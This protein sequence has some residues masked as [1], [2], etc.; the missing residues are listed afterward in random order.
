MSHLGDYFRIRRQEK[1]VTSG[2]L[3]RTVGYQNL[4]RGSNRIQT[5]E[6]GGKVAPDLLGKLATALEV[7]PDEVRRL[8]AEDYQEWL[9]WA[10]EPIRPHLVLRWT[11]CVYQRLELPDDALEAGA[12]QEYASC[13][14]RDRRLMVCLVLSRRL[15]VGFD[16]TG[17]EYKRLE[18]TPEVPCEP[19]VVIGGKRV[20]FDLSGGG[21]LH[22]IDEQG[23]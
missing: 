5:F 7:T 22:P 23:H 17:N 16:S 18:A 15:S 4:S 3:A 10:N 20:Q 9:D 19:Y 11:A 13:L 12:A 2:Q 6:G 21:V 14:A 1:G 8:A